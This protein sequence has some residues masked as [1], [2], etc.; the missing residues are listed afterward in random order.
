MALTKV[1]AAGLTADLIDETKLADNSIDS[2]HYN[3]GSIDHEHLANDAVDADILADNSV[4]LAAMAGGTDGV[5]ITYDA[6]GDPVHVG[7]GSDGQVLTSTGAGSPPAFETPAPGVGGATGVDF[8]D[9]VKVRLGTGNDLEIFHDGTGGNSYIKDVGTG[10]LIVTTDSLIQVQKGTSEVLAKFTPD[11][12]AELYYDNSKKFE[13]LSNGVKVTG[14]IE[15]LESGADVR[16]KNDGGKLVCG[17]SDDLQIYHDG[18]H[19]YITDS[20]TGQLRIQTDTFSVENAAG[21]EN[22]ILANE[23][24]AVQLFHNNVKKLETTANGATVTGHISGAHGVLEQFFCVC[25]GS[26]IALTS[27]NRTVQ[28]VTADMALNNTFTDLTGSTIAYTPPAGAKQVIY[29]FHFACTPEDANIIFHTKLFLDSDEVNMA[30][31]SYRANDSFTDRI[32]QKW[33]FNIGGTADTNSGRVA[34]WTSDK[35]IK[36]QAREY[37]TGNEAYLHRLTNWDGSGTDVEAPDAA[38]PC[39]GITAIG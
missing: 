10:G 3:D 31:M 34:S 27:G 39:I 25:D 2:E 22:V 11:G 26:T 7:P 16:I 9:D 24:G 33:A 30:R 29:E 38:M 21:S 36:M 18:N 5:I 17:A 1:Q 28:D 35:T 13:T 23:D 8:N 20:G 4:G 37:S 12:A 14:N 15:V 6:N 32:V 19:S